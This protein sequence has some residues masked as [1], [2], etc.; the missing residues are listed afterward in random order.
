MLRLKQ[1]NNKGDVIDWYDMESGIKVKHNQ[2]NKETGYYWNEFAG[3]WC[4]K[5]SKKKLLAD[6]KIKVYDFKYYGLNRIVEDLGL[7]Q[8][9]SVGLFLTV[10]YQKQVG[11]GFKAE[12]WNFVYWNV[13]ELR[14]YLGYKY[15]DIINILSL[16]R[17]IYVDRPISKVRG[18]RRKWLIMLNK[19]FKEVHGDIYDIVSLKD[20]KL[21][22]SIISY[23]KKII[24]Q[25]DNNLKNLEVVLNNTSLIINDLDI[26]LEHMWLRKLEL[27]KADLASEFVSKK[28][29]K[30]IN[31]K[32]ADLDVYKIDYK[33]D[34]KRYYNYIDQVQHT[35]LDEQKRVLYA[36]IKSDFGGRISHLYSN[37][38]K[39]FRKFLRID[40]EEVVEVDIVASQP[41]FLCL[42]FERGA[43]MSRLKD[44]FNH[45]NQ[46]YLDMMHDLSSIQ[47]LD[48]YRYMAVKSRFTRGGSGG[49]RTG[50]PASDVPYLRCDGVGQTI[51]SVAWR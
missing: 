25:R 5:K 23:Y 12:D 17:I 18:D 29:K 48:I 41:S 1:L 8:K 28:D 31:K 40:S 16:K 44:I 35:E 7:M 39:L 26:I 10:Q 37:A 21:E 46:G 42:L 14:R 38:P 6:S 27:N 51:F 36:L 32:Q 24:S 4:I 30:A 34:L 19:G 2:K 45:D 47:G 11:S 13:D 3:R 9:E 20:N 43:R 15:D 33:R 50:H 22:K 49:D